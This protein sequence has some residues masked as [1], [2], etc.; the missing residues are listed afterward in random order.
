MKQFTNF[1]FKLS[2]NSNVAIV[3]SNCDLSKM[4]EPATRQNKCPVKQ[5]KA[6]A[7]RQIKSQ[8]NRVRKN[9]MPSE[10]LIALRVYQLLNRKIFDKETYTQ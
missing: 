10:E 9:Y 3:V 5:K 1:M 4:N 2:T 8:F 6:H 7:M